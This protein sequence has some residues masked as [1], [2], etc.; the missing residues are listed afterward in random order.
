M[1]NSMKIR[2][3]E[4]ILDSP[5]TLVYWFKMNVTPWLHPQ[6]ISHHVTLV[7]GPSE[8]EINLPFGSK[9]KVHVLGYIDTCDVQAVMV[10]LEGATSKNDF[11]HVTVAVQPGIPPAD[12]N[13]HIHNWIELEGPVLEGTLGF[14]TGSNHYTDLTPLRGD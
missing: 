7:F 14:C 11:P 1:S 6:V 8:K 5:D 10:R 9:V 12:T 4:V 2:Y 3:T 13:K